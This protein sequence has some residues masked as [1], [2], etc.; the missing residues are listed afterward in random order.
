M[1]TSI[2]KSVKKVVGISAT[3]TSFD[4][5]ILMHTNT[6]LATLNQLGVGPEGGISV[7][8]DSATWASV[9]GTDQRYSA[10]KSYVYAKVKL[11]FDPPTTSFLLEALQENVREMEWRLNTVRETDNFEPNETVLD[12]GDVEFDPSGS[13]D[14]GAP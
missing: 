12:G 14:G 3:D 7:Y 5:D 10:V 8:D 9:F 2:L 11:L 6:A 13:A 4:E 1:E